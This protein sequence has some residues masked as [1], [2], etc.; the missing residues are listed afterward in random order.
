MVPFPR[1]SVRTDHRD[2]RLT[3]LQTV[4]ADRK[5]PGGFRE[6]VFGDRKKNIYFR[7]G[8]GRRAPEDRP[9]THRLHF[10]RE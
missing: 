10:A 4:T 2:F 3:G 7:L 1:L 6:G 9:S 8:G 5:A